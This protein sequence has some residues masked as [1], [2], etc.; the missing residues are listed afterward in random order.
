[1]PKVFLCAHVLLAPVLS[2]QQLEPGARY[3]DCNNYDTEK[4]FI[5]YLSLIGTKENTD[6]DDVISFVCQL[7]L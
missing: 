7:L 1:M 2:V 4:S 5:I 6:S 3:T